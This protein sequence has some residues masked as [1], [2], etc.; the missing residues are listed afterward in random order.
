MQFR[1]PSAAYGVWRWS[2][3]N[4]ECPRHLNLRRPPRC[5]PE[6]V[7]QHLLWP[8]LPSQ[9]SDSQLPSQP[10]RDWRRRRRVQHPA[11]CILTNGGGDFLAFENLPDGSLSASTRRDLDH[12]FGPDWPDVEYLT[13]DAYFGD[14]ELPPPANT[15]GK[16]FVGLLPGLTAPFSRGNVTIISNDTSVNRSYHPI[17][18]KTPATAEVLIAAFRRARDVWA[19]KSMQD[20]IIGPE[21]FPGANVTSASDIL[22]AINV[23]LRRSGTRAPPIRWVDGTIQWQWLILVPKSS[24]YR[25]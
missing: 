15:I 21:A 20:V 24:G 22:T 23:A 7:G 8:Y 12:A 17:G 9:C 6:P 13:V 2:S 3:R 19:T 16:N 25:V 1:S 10:S 18:W 11:H 4:L 14:Q 5:G